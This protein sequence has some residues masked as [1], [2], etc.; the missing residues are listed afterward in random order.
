MLEMPDLRRLFGGCL[1]RLRSIFWESV[2]FMDRRGFIWVFE[3]KESQFL[4]FCLLNETGEYV[5]RK[6]TKPD[7]FEPVFPLFGTKHHGEQQL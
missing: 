7:A 6:K 4:R 3:A 1:G 5:L 2:F